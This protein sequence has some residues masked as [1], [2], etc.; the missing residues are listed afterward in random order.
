MGKDDACRKCF[1][2]CSDGNPFCPHLSTTEDKNY[3]C[4]Q[5]LSQLLSKSSTIVGLQFDIDDLICNS[6]R[7]TDW[8]FGSTLY[9][10]SNALSNEK[11]NT[12][13]SDK[14]FLSSVFLYD[15]VMEGMPKVKRYFIILALLQQCI[16]CGWYLLLP[17]E[18]LQ[19]YRIS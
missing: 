15:F 2:V 12:G 10:K 16:I 7:D 9:E 11:E 3:G 5:S 18:D 17:S 13:H 6:I 19:A 8:I 14:W 4:L 1:N